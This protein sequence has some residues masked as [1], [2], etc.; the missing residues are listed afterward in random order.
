MPGSIKNRPF[1]NIKAS[2]FFWS[3][4]MLELCVLSKTRSQRLPEGIGCEPYW[5]H[6]ARCRELRMIHEMLPPPSQV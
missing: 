6:I 2:M 4:S 1:L 3:E 5:Q